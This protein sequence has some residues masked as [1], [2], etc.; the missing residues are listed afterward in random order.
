MNTTADFTI[1]K[2]AWH[3]RVEDNP[4]APEL[5][6]YRFKIIAEFLQSHGLTVRPLLGHDVEPDEEFSIRTNDLTSD[7]LQVMRLAY[8]QWL[9][10]I[11]NK[12]KN[13]ND[14]TIFE[15]ALSRV[16]AE[17]RTKS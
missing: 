4:E 3:T 15:M 5:V 11:V 8:D 7:G 9:K 12:R 6:K 14:L 13:V 1:D 10:K 16:R 17:G 2:V